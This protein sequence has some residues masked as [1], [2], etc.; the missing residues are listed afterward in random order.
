MCFDVRKLIRFA[1][2][3][4]RKFQT[5][6]NYTYVSILNEGL[7]KTQEDKAKAELFTKYNNLFTLI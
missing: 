1:K 7:Y 3:I 6:R 5:N 4:I 2:A